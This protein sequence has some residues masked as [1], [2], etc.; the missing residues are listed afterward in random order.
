VDQSEMDQ[1]FN[2]GIGLVL[3]VSPYYAESIRH[4]LTDFGLNSSVIGRVRKGRRAV[5]WSEDGSRS[6]QKQ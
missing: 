5:V 1:V 6:R 2:M 4:Q 3:L